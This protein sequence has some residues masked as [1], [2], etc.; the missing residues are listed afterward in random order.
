MNNLV[1]ENV[2]IVIIGDEILSGRTRDTNFNFIS[3][4]LLKYGI[5]VSECRIIS[6]SKNEIISTVNELRKKYKYV[7]TTGGI[8][9][10]H[11][12]ITS[13]SMAD[14][15]GVEIES[16]QDAFNILSDYYKNIGANFNE[17]R[18]RMAKI[19]LGAKL[20]KNQISAAPGFKIENVFV[21]AGV[22]KIMKSML[23]EV[24]QYMDQ[25]EKAINIK[26]KVMAPEG[27]IANILEKIIEKHSDVKIGSYPFFESDKI[28]G[29]N[30]E[31]NSYNDNSIKN[32]LKFLKIH[33]SE[34]SINYK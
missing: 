14:A 8:G 15:F 23:N 31:L 19:P 12:D 18:Q 1:S 13:E 11:D 9:P 6:D 7:I 3:K 16:N 4:N 27:E 28:F 17:A 26:L 5:L 25:K 33:L 22:P 24:I 34:E 20:I 2:A 21:L 30:L 29:V 10:T 32:A